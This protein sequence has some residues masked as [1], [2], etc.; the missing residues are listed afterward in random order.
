MSPYREDLIGLEIANGRY[1]VLAR[2]GQGSMGQVYL[3]HDRHLQTDI[4]L[5]F[6]FAADKSSSRP[7]F[8]DRF[9]REIRSLVEL[10]HPHIVKVFDVGELESYPFVVMQFLTGGTLKDRI[11][12]GPAQEAVA[13]PPQSL[14]DW[15]LEIAK[16]LDFIHDRKYIHRNVKPANILF[17]RYGHAFLGDFGIIKALTSEQ[18]NSRENSLTAPGFLVGTPNYV[19][20]EIVMGRS[21]DGRVD[22]YS[23]AMTV[24]EALSGINCMAGPTPSATVVN[25]TIVVPPALTELIPSISGRLSSALSRGLSK[26][27]AARFAS[28]AALAQE[29][30]AAVPSSTTTDIGSSATTKTTR[31]QPGRVACPACQAPIPVGREHA[32]GRVRC[33][34]CQATSL[35]SLLSSN[36]VQ[37]KLLDDRLSS[38]H[39]PDPIVVESPDDEAGKTGPLSARRPS[40]G[41]HIATAKAALSWNSRKNV[42]I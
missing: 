5:K 19:A 29:I 28:C 22:Q 7:E 2:V 33:T 16:A 1:E 3:A 42:L 15:L 20:P 38:A 6:P 24:H 32:G 17:D 14:K 34:G 41:E 12:S 26:E 9:I 21:F 35:V 39:L 10:T 13:M 30:L 40:S 36:T 8:L 31:G 37:L 11:A 23:L 27:P 4:V 18:A 25:Q